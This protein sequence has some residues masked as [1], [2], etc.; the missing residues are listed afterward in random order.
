[1]DPMCVLWLFLLL[2]ECFHCR[3]DN[4]AAQ[5]I[6]SFSVS[7]TKKKK[8]IKICTFISFQRGNKSVRVQSAL[9]AQETRLVTNTNN[10]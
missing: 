1:M 6:F 9:E 2:Y 10:Y 8:K 3:G 5:Y 4:L 7:K